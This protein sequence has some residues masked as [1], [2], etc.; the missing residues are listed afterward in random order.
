[1]CEVNDQELLENEEYDHELAREL[2]IYTSS[3]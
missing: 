1:M 3:S 2:N